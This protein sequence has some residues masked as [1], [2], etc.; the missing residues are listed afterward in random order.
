[1]ETGNNKTLTEDDFIVHD[2]E[3]DSKNTDSDSK[4]GDQNHTRIEWND[5]EI[6]VV[7]DTYTKHS[8]EGVKKFLEKLRMEKSLQKSSF[9]VSSVKRINV[10]VLG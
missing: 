8:S 7:M 2:S 9:Q 3:I 1:M 10:E 6:S 4:N 5:E